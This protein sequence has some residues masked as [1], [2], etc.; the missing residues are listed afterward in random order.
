MATPKN[1]DGS[2]KELRLDLDEPVLEWGEI[3]IFDPDPDEVDQ[4]ELFFKLRRFLIKRGNWTRR[5]IDKLTK[6]DSREIIESVGQAI[7]DRAVP[8]ANGSTSDD[9]PAAK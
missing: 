8:K 6:D 2:D 3:S 5:E 7:K 9:G 1:E 4:N